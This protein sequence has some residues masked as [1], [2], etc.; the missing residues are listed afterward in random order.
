[1]I[2][3]QHP[4]YK[5]LSQDK[6][7]AIDLLHTVRDLIEVGAKQ[8]DD[9]AKALY[10]LWLKNETTLQT[11]WGFDEGA[12]WIRWWNYPRCSCPKM[13]NDDAW[14]N[15]WYTKSGACPIHGSEVDQ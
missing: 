7:L 3:T 13:D 10:S 2:N 8:S 12:G 11:L 4:K 15:G 14:P 1:M 5:T 9:V 6:V